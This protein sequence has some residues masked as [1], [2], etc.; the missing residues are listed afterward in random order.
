MSKN[1]SISDRERSVGLESRYVLFRDKDQ[2]V[3]N[4]H[5]NLSAPGCPLVQVDPLQRKTPYYVNQIIMTPREFENK[6]ASSSA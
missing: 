2:V 3:I 5:W 6:F 4:E 1:I